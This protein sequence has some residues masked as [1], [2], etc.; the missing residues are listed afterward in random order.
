MFDADQDD[1]ITDDDIE[2]LYRESYDVTESVLNH[3]DELEFSNHAEILGMLMAAVSLQGEGM[4]QMPPDMLE[5]FC[6]SNEIEVI[7][8]NVIQF[9]HDE[10]RD[11][12]RREAEKC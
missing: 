3:L 8:G 1:D 11:W 9:I 5:R 10:I 2:E 12:L 6:S 4:K 7:S